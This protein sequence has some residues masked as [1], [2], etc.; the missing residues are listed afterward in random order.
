MVS[1]TVEE[2]E[3]EKRTKGH[4]KRLREKC[5]RVSMGAYLTQQ[6]SDVTDNKRTSVLW[7]TEQTDTHTVGK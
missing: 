6:D 5:Q 2:S 3:E 7:L 4:S 1:E